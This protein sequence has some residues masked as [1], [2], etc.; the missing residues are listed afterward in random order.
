MPPSRTPAHSSRQLSP[1]TF[2][3]CH[4]K[5]SF[6]PV[7][8]VPPPSLPPARCITPAEPCDIL[9]IPLEVL[10][11]ATVPAVM[12]PSRTPARCITPADPCSILLIPPPLL[13]PA[14]VAP[15]LM[16]TSPVP[17]FVLSITDEEPATIKNRWRQRRSTFGCILT[18][19]Q[20]T[21]FAYSRVFANLELA[22]ALIG[23]PHGRRPKMGSLKAL[24]K[25]CRGTQSL[26][27]TEH[28]RDVFALVKVICIKDCSSRNAQFLTFV[29]FEMF[30]ICKNKT[31]C[32]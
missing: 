2:W 21:H 12:P 15:E 27:S 29:N 25:L 20:L 13:T 7:P 16:L 6:L 9:E 8:D 10:F 24:H 18:F 4:R 22:R 28:S 32:C 11:P 14:A 17:P 1:A 23:S 5:C 26:E 30:S 19:L 3:K 31:Y